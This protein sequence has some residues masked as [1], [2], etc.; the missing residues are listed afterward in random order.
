MSGFLISHFGP[1]AAYFFGIFLQS[2]G[3]ASTVLMIGRGRELAAE[4]MNST[5]SSFDGLLDTEEVRIEGLIARVHLDLDT[6]MMLRDP[7][8]DPCR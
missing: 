4:L 8:A 1:A 2:A 7:R 5:R 6:P 3:C